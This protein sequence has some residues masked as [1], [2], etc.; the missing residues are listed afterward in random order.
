MYIYV[1]IYMKILKEC[2]LKWVVLIFH[3]NMNHS[4]IDF[5]FIKMFQ[6][7]EF[8]KHSQNSL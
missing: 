4:L 1:Y 5:V 2:A 7:S 6:C 8:G 3:R